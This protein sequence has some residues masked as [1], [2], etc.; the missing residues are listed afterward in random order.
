MTNHRWGDRSA[1]HST[2][3]LP[4]ST[5]LAKK[6][7]FAKNRDKKEAAIRFHLFI[8]TKLSSKF[9]L[10]IYQLFRLMDPEL[11]SGQETYQYMELCR[12][13]IYILSAIILFLIG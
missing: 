3:P 1:E 5:S 8:Q 11:R 2:N 13:E 9:P 10:I 6:K 12:F 7:K 4:Y